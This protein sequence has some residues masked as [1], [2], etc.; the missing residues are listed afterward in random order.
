[1][2]D[3]G[4][5]SVTDQDALDDVEGRLRPGDQGSAPEPRPLAAGLAGW[6]RWVWRSLTS[7]RTALILLLFLVL[8]AIP[9]SVFPQRASDEL[10]VNDYLR[11]NPTLGPILDRLGMFEVFGSPWF[12]AIYLLLFISLVGCVVPRSRQLYRQWREGPA[13]PPRRIA[14]RPAAVSVP[15]DE[16]ALATAADHLRAAGWRVST[17]PDWVSAEKGFLRELGNLGFHLSLV[18]LLVAV[19]VGSLFGWRGSVVV[20]EGKGFANTLTQYDQW[21]GGRAVDPAALA[22]FA[23]TLDSF[24]VAFERGEAQRGAPRDFRAVVSLQRNPGAAPE[25]VLLSVNK[26]L[27]V[28]GADVYLIGHGY[29]P[30]LKVT[31]PQGA[32]LFDDSVVFLPRDANFTSTGVVKLPDAEPQLAFNGIFAPTAVVDDDGPHSIFPAPDAPGLFLAAFTGDLGLDTGVPQ[33]VYKLDTTG[34]EQIGLKGLV[35][36]QSWQLPDGNTVTFVAV[37]RY[38]SLKI[39]KDPGRLWALLAVSLVMTGL[40][41]SLFV[42]RRRI[43]LRRGD[44]EVQIAGLARTENAAPHKDV[45]QLADMLAEQHPPVGENGPGTVG[46]GVHR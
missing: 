5:V 33:S 20:P 9:G 22:P 45:Q 44:G 4:P 30:R 18:V 8:A 13:E 29:A 36:G 10:A 11:N 41:L 7:M 19:A 14:E 24:D 28:D 31:S 40:I 6:G 27:R 43:W 42:P 1:M 15:A 38:V 16:G 32:V 35:P 39:S 37:D 26:P 3:N 25:Q 23:F 17:G 12:A 2:G 21:S 46:Q 34:L